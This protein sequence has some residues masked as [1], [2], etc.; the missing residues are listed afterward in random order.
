MRKLEEK[1]AARKQGLRT[2]SYAQTAA[3]TAMQSHNV[4]EFQATGDAQLK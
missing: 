4:H 1:Q 3:K 2:T